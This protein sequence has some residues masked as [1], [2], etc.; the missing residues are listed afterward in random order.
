VSRYISFRAGGTSRD[1]GVGEP[2]LLTGAP[3]SGFRLMNG[4]EVA[5]AVTAKHILFAVHGFNTDFRRGAAQ[6]AGFDA[7]LALSSSAAFWGVLWPGDAWMPYVNYPFEAE[8]AVECG[9]RLAT[10]CAGRFRDAASFSFLSHSLGGRVVLE[11]VKRLPQDRKARMMCL[12]AA[13][14]D[15]DALTRHYKAALGKSE[16]VYVLS[17]AKDDVLKLAYPVGDFFSDLFGDSDSPFKGALGL[18]G[19]NPSAGPTVDDNRIARS[20]PCSHRGYLPNESHWQH[21]PDY[22]RRS[23]NRQPHTWPV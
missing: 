18:K 15:R 23:F 3:A 21:I 19:P 17:S 11:A 5:S 8:D 4:A 14:V 2:L 22:V 16:H 10:L 12:M 6:M 13:A 7:A 1:L 20:P 9:K